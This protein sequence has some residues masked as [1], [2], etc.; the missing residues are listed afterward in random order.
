MVGPTLSN[1]R[2]GNLGFPDHK[3]ENSPRFVLCQT[4]KIPMP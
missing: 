1:L 4:V 2:Q 3:P